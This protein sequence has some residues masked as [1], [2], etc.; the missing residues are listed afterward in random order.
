MEGYYEYYTSS[1]SISNFNK[2]KELCFYLFYI[3]IKVGN[4]Y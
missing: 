1:I 2:M 4:N 3:F